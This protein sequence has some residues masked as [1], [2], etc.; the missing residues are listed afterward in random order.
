MIDEQRKIHLAA[1]MCATVGSLGGKQLV[2]FVDIDELPVGTILYS[3]P[4]VQS[5]FLTDERIDWIA[6]SHCPDNR[7]RPSNVKAAIREA[8]AEAAQ[9]AGQEPVA[10]LSLCADSRE[11]QWAEQERQLSHGNYDV[12]V[13]PVGEAFAAPVK[14]AQQK[15]VAWR[16]SYVSPL[17][18]ARVYYVAQTETRARDLVAG[19]PHIEIEPLG[20]IPAPVNGGEHEKTAIHD[21]WKRVPLK[22]TDEMIHS[23]RYGG[24]KARPVIGEK[25]DS[26]E[27]A[28][29]FVAAHVM[30]R[31][32]RAMLDD[33]SSAADAQQVGGDVLTL[34]RDARSHLVAPASGHDDGLLLADLIERIDAALTSPAKEQK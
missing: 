2:W 4:A 27:T 3:T 9:S 16:S 31:M 21:G 14:G 24:D 8:L 1:E 12:Y 5:A 33:A 10:R 17:T 11:L 20:V 19:C 22:P 25:S 13:V 32:Y 7:A 30:D 26:E 28:T 23:G 18:D 15:A 34:L 6:N 29:P